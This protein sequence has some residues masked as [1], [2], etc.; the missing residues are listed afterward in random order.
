MG[1]RHTMLGL[2]YVA[3]VGLMACM[4]APS[5]SDLI[6]KHPLEGKTGP[7]KLLVIVNG[8]FVENTNYEELGVAIQK[9]SPLK[10]WLALPSFIAN[11]PNPGEMSSKVAAAVSAVRE[12]N[13][14]SINSTSDVFIS[15][16]SLG[17]IMSQ[18]EVASGKYQAGLI[19]FGSYLTSTF[20]NSMASFKYPVLTLAGELDGLT[21]ITRI[22]HEWQGMQGRIKSDGPDAVY[23][24]P[25]FAL[26]GQSHSQFCSGVN[27]TS[28]GTKDLRPE[29]SWEAA[30]QAIAASV[31]AFMTLAINPTD[32]TARSFVDDRVKYTSTLLQGW[33][34]AQAYENQVCEEAQKTNAANVTAQ[35]TVGTTHTGNFVSFG[36]TYPSVNKD[37]EI[38][39]V[40]EVQHALNPGDTSTIDV[41]ASEVDCKVLTERAVLDAFGGNATIGN[42][43]CQQSNEAMLSMAM[44]AVTSTTLSR[45]QKEGKPFRMG[46]DVE[47]STGVTWQAGGFQ[48]KPE[49][50]SVSVQSPVLT[51]GDYLLCKLMSP[52]RIVEYMMVD[53]LPRFDGS[54][55]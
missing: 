19:L 50:S 20:G 27:V 23:K 5:L 28:F 40:D 55:P 32:S 31:T 3:L 9:A 43:G 12:S 36:A 2:R 1:N 29:V 34:A 13:F 6:V 17:G 4:I 39:V 21:R 8:A 51:S 25:V 18:S 42:Q 45:Y 30:H 48:F 54:V 53:G 38:M 24:Y 47:Y 35:F 37:G 22:G 16:H 11:T 46:P 33:L 15:G 10:L 44:K 49:E 14:S 26:P 52:S 41:S 7:E